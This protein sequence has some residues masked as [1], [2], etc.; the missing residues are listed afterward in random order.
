MDVGESGA[1]GVR[2]RVE[3]SRVLPLPGVPSRK[4]DGVA[5]HSC[6]AARDVEA[7]AAL[8]TCRLG[9][10]TSRSAGGGD[11]V[12]RAMSSL[13]GST[14]HASG[15]VGTVSFEEKWRDHSGDAWLLLLTCRGRCGLGT[16]ESVRRL[17][18]A[19]SGSPRAIAGE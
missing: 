7:I 4:R 15:E 11:G 2:V 9:V 18:C 19:C 6:G 3:K 14:S 16:S 10:M 5:G 12:H 8:G 13:N 1:A 17:T